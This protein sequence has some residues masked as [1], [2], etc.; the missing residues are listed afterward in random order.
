M[1]EKGGT[2]EK[3]MSRV[4]HALSSFIS[5]S[6]IIYSFDDAN[7]FAIYLFF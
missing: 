6:T 2:F 5:I 7:C 4:G 3:R 1:K